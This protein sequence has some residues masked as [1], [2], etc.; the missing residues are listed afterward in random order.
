MRLGSYGSNWIGFQQQAI[1]NFKGTIQKSVSRPISQSLPVVCKGNQFAPR[2]SAESVQRVEIRLESRELCVSL[3]WLSLSLDCLPVF[4]VIDWMLRT[5][6]IADWLSRST[7]YRSC[8]QS[9]MVARYQSDDMMKDGKR[10]SAELPTVIFDSE[11]LNLWLRSTVSVAE[12][13]AETVAETVAGACVVAQRH[14]VESV[15]VILNHARSPDHESDQLDSWIPVHIL[16]HPTL[17]SRLQS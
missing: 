12:A 9:C 15:F 11:Y 8:R 4:A 3:L 5:I 14:E 10:K 17:A 1:F 7:C 13:V 6:D 16:P 2:R